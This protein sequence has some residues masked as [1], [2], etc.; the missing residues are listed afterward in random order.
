[1]Y[2]LLQTEPASQ[3]RMVR[4]LAKLQPVEFEIRVPFETDVDRVRKL[5]KKVGQEMMQDPE[6]APMLLDPLKSQ[7]VNRMDDSAFIVRCKFTAKPGKQFLARRVAYT[8][9]Q[10][11]FRREGIQFAPRRVIVETISPNPDPTLVAGAAL[12]DDKDND[13]PGA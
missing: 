10:E 1:M 6:L 8:R 13:K 2:Q 11:A 12:A 7:G 5:I 3:A 9:I 4:V